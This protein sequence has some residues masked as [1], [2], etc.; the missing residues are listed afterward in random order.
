MWAVKAVDDLGPSLCAQVTRAKAGQVL[1][2]GYVKVLRK[3]FFDAPAR[4][5]SI[6]GGGCTCGSTAG[7]NSG[8]LGSSKLSLVTAALGQGTGRDVDGGEGRDSRCRL[9]TKMG[10]REG[11]EEGP[12]SARK[13]TRS[14]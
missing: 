3:L 1:H 2:T 7:A 13:T 12:L 10:R 5:R 4:R 8:V 14:S 11:G 6:A 9:E